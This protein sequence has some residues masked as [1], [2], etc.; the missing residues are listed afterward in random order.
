MSKPARPLSSRKDR[1]RAD[2]I[3]IAQAL[4]FQ[5][6]Y[7]QTSMSQIAA[8]VGGSKATL[9]NHFQSKEEL[10][11]AVVADVVATRPEDYDEATMPELGQI[12]AWL[13]WFGRALVRKITAPNYIALQRLAA[14]EALRYPEIGKSFYDA[15]MPGIDMISSTFTMA[16]EQGLL[17]RGDPKVA[18][19]HFMELCLGWTARRMVWNIQATLSEPELDETVSAAISTFMDGYAPAA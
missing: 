17:R 15:M 16:M 5:E 18:A 11:L 9:Y 13:T 7:A 19:L 3:A 14:A 10:L 2:I 1:K 6:G 12:R 4:F 8:R